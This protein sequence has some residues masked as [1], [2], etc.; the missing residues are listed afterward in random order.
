MID[1]DLFS[2]NNKWMIQCPRVFNVMKKIGTVDT[3]QDLLDKIFIPLFEVTIDP[4]K[5]PKL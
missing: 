1:N 5:N 3:F 4:S 2:P